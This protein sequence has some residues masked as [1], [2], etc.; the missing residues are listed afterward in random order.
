MQCAVLRSPHVTGDDKP[1]G[2]RDRATIRDVAQK[3]GVHPSLVS[4][5]VNN[6]PKAYASVETRARI[7]QAVAEL[8]YR[9]HSMARGLRMARAHTLGLLIPDLTN[10]MYA[11]IVAGVEARAADLGYG[12]VFGSHAEGSPQSTFTRL[13]EE[14][15]VDGLLVASAVLKDSYMRNVAQT[16]VGPVVLVNRRVRG[17]SSSVVVDDDAGAA[18]AVDHLV[19]LG[20]RSIAGVFGPAN[21]DTARRRRAGFVRACSTV[22]ITP[23]IVEQ[24]SWTANAGYQA[25]LTAIGTPEPPTA[26][27]ASSLMMGLGVLRAAHELGIQVPDD[28]S[29][30]ALHDSEIASYVQPQLTT[31]AMP[32][33]AMGREAADLIIS[34]IEGEPGRHVVVDDAPQ[35]IARSSTAPPPHH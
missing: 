25:G 21:I 3:A 30:I 11:S 19:S 14:G 16:G 24:S 2:G 17:I 10:P 18:L 5:V 23:Q 7:L 22:G 6:H 12:V 4:R 15:R 29:V 26:I 20:H 9:P 31:I 33:E 32:T 35:L 1:T 8:D 34:M 13:L 27:F 28:I